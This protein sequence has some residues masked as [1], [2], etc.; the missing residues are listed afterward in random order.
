MRNNFTLTKPLTALYLLIALCISYYFFS[1]IYFT[2]LLSD[3]LA[4]SSSITNLQY[5][6]EKHGCYLP[7]IPNDI[8]LKQRIQTLDGKWK[9]VLKVIK[10][11]SNKKKIPNLLW[12]TR[13]DIPLILPNYTQITFNNNPTWHPFIMIDDDINY[14][15][16]HIFYN[17][18][19]LW[20]FTHINPMLGAVRADIWRYAV[21]LI[22]GGKDYTWIYVFICM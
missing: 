22:F 10:N 15:M 20:A 18:S 21:L 2:S 11:L 17:T 7:Y 14:F 5:N 6:C 8:E 9:N 1:D 3:S 16:N 19:I 4:S 12:L 13:K